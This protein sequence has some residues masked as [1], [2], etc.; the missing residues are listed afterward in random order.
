MSFVSPDIADSI[1]AQVT[2][3]WQTTDPLLPEPAPLTEGCGEA[4]I[5]T[6]PDGH[7]AAFAS[8]EHWRGEPESLD[9]TWGAA[10][11]FQLTPRI[12]GP[13]VA[14]ALDSLLLQWASHLA[15]TS[16]AYDEDSAAIVSWPSRDVTGAATLLR[17]GFAPMAVIAART[18]KRATPAGSDGTGEP[19][20]GPAR[21]GLS[22]RRATPAD[23]ADV[24]RLGIETVRYD[25][26]FGG[27][28]ERSWTATALQH[29]ADRFLAADE[30]WIWLA[31]RDGTGIG[32]LFAEPPGAAGWIAPLVS[33]APVA[34]LL[35]LGVLPGE[36]GG[37]VGAALTARF[38]SE[39]D[40]A[41]VAV[42][43]LHY[44]QT[45]PLSAPFWGR[46]GYRP[47][48]TV[49]ETRPARAIR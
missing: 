13:D 41:G 40:T 16:A 1:N 10:R 49:W 43:L 27:V 46:Q 19:A 48:W 37:G 38:H 28:N 35:L 2:S 29:E 36:R 5:A 25:S 20:S 31:E 11:R 7:P 3:L 22:I 33:R 47:L 30:P 23:A 42:T 9:L 18:T 32:M 15:R 8:C 14:G 24:A 21:A 26:Y 45:N 39:L 4:L 44:A 12:A 17:H 34:Y 6:A